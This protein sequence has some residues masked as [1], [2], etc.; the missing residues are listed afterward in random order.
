MLLRESS[1]EFT[2]ERV[3]SE[4]YIQVQPAADHL[5]KLDASGLVTRTSADPPKYRYATRSND[6]DRAV[7]DLAGLYGIMRLRIITEIMSNPHDSIQ[8]FADAFKFRK[9]KDNEE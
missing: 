5:A 1:T 2:P 4:L 8:S 7:R 6:Q 9:D 3:A